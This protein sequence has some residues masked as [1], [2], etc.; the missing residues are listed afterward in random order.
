LSSKVPRCAPRQASVRPSEIERAVALAG[1]ESLELD[2]PPPALLGGYADVLVPSVRARESMRSW[3][4]R[5][6]ATKLAPDTVAWPTLPASRCKSRS[7]RCAPAERVVFVLDDM[8]VVGNTRLVTRPFDLARNP[9]ELDCPL[10]QGCFDRGSVMNETAYK[11]KKDPDRNGPSEGAGF[12]RESR[13]REPTVGWPQR[14]RRDGARR[15]EQ[16]R[17]PRLRTVAG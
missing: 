12:R 5:G 16:R 11:K 14:P 13:I 10:V 6:L 15:E 1:W 7:P 17:R 4:I 8:F 2:D 9:A 3:A